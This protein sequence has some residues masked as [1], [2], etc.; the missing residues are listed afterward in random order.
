HFD[1]RVELCCCCCK[2]YAARANSDWPTTRGDLGEGGIRTLDNSKELI[3]TVLVE[4]VRP[5]DFVA[6]ALAF[7]NL[8]ALADTADEAIARVRSLLSYQVRDAKAHGEP[9]PVDVPQDCRDGQRC[10]T[11]TIAA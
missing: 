1:E 4:E 8:L 3:Y 9:V 2:G 7:P 5:H 6:R 11:V 10:V